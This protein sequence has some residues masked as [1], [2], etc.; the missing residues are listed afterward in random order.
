MI[1]PIAL[2]MKHSWEKLV[3]IPCDTLWYLVIPCDTLWYLVIPCD[4]LWYLVIPC[5]TL[6]YIVI[7]CDTLWHL[8]TYMSALWNNC[9]FKQPHFK[10]FPSNIKAYVTRAIFSSKTFLRLGNA[11]LSTSVLKRSQKGILP[12]LLKKLSAIKCLH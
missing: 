4:T 9:K 1:H 5:D 3:V 7:P 12:N 2:K 6:W 10:Y 8:V 11:E